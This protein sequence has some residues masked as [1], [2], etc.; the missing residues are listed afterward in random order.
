MFLFQSLIDYVSIQKEVV[1]KDT[2]EYTDLVLLFSV[3]EATQPNCLLNDA[4][5]L[6]Y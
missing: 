2:T 4:N 5:I 6:G 3:L 1:S